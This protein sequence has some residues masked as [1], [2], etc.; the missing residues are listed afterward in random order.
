MKLFRYLSYMVIF[1]SQ[2]CK[3]KCNDPGNPECQNYNPCFGKSETSAEF[4]VEED[5]LGFGLEG[6]WYKADSITPSFNNSVR[7]SALNNAD[8]FIWTIGGGVYNTKSVVLNS[9]IPNSTVE[10]TLIVF[11]K[12]PNVLCFPND[13]G[14]DTFVRTICVWP[15][16]KERI[17]GVYGY[18]VLT[19]P[20]PISGYYQGYY[21]SHPNQKTIVA[22][23]DSIYQP[24]PN[25]PLKRD[26]D[27][28]GVSRNIPLGYLPQINSNNFYYGAWNQ[29]NIVFAKFFAGEVF[30]KKPLGKDSTIEI[31]GSAIL[32]S[33][34]KTIDI[35][36]KW[37]I[38]Q[39]PEENWKH[40]K[41]VGTKLE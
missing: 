4:I 38:G 34:R 11:N 32:R 21:Q 25:T 2:S 40:D 6:I 9:F 36:V 41:F 37:N 13:D 27:V 35:N 5:L 12:N 3:D 14:K 23:F 19:N 8:S 28:R 33:D 18:T 30:E 29:R 20:Y 26:W 17:G 1:L 24:A 16:I 31:I 10:I 22:L 7:F 39:Y 15:R